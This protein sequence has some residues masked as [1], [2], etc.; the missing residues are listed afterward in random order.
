LAPVCEQFS[1]GEVNVPIFTTFL[2]EVASRAEGPE[3]SA[4][5]RKDLDDQFARLR[6]HLLSSDQDDTSGLKL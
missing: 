5:N 4:I 1:A 2:T 3:S 6:A